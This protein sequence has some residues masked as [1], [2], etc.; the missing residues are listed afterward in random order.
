MDFLRLDSNY[1]EQILGLEACFSGESWN[2][3]Q[4]ENELNNPVA[5]LYGLVE[6]NQLLAYCAIRKI[7]DEAELLKVV[8][9]KAFQRRG[10]AQKL[11]ITAFEK[12]NTVEK[13]YLEV[14]ETNSA[15]IQLY[16]KLGFV[17]AGCRKNFYNNPIADALIMH[18]IVKK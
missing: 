18:K 17:N 6:N 5:E 12:L 2:K 9:A 1:L 13:I 7:V 3:I 14:R 10:L 4:I 16:G 11:L 8:T 15:A